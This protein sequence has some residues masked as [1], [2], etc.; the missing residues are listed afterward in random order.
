MFPFGANSDL[1]RNCTLRRNCPTGTSEFT[2]FWRQLGSPLGIKIPGDSLSGIPLWFCWRLG[3]NSFWCQLGSSLELSRWHLGINSLW[4]QL[5]SPLGFAI[6]WDSFLG[7]PLCINSFWCQLGSSFELSHWHLGI[8]SIWRQLGSPLGFAIPIDY[9]SG[10]P[11]C[12]PPVGVYSA[13]SFVGNYIFPRW[14]FTIILL[15]W[16]TTYLL[17]WHMIGSHYDFFPW[18]GVIV[19]VVLPLSPF[20][21]LK[22]FGP[23][24]PPFTISG[25]F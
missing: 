10:I 9:F 15:S 24:Q 4:R 7:I 13:Y 16:G 3:I 19:N 11:P 23:N 2:S 8:N 12:F 5:G 14:G 6:P 22:I 17:W 25:I 20:F 18:W 1:R 21:V